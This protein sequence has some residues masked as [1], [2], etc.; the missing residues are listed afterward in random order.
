MATCEGC[1]AA[2]QP[3][4]SKH[5][6]HSTDCRRQAQWK[7]KW[8]PNRA[9]LEE[10]LKAMATGQEHRALAAA[11]RH[12]ADIVD[13]LPAFDDKAWREYRLALEALGKAVNTD[14][15]APS[16]EDLVA[17]LRAEVPDPANA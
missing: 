2:F 9:A 11:C 12:L 13:A 10:Q 1:G 15:R 6:F 16:F 4:H 7:P 8:G 17:G 3:K 5:R 14:A